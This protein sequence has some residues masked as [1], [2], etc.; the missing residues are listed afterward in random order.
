M[1]NVV[2]HPVG[3]QR[4]PFPA[5]QQHHQRQEDKLALVVQGLIPEIGR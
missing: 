1:V 3:V 5:V 4:E 2:G